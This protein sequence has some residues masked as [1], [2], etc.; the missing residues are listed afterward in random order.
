[1][2]SFPTQNQVLNAVHTTFTEFAHANCDTDQFYSYQ[3]PP[4]HFQRK[5][6]C[7]HTTTID[8][9][10]VSAVSRLQLS[11]C[12]PAL[13]LSA[14]GVKLTQVLHETSPYTKA[15]AVLPRNDTANR[16]ARGIRTVK[17]NEWKPPLYDHLR[18]CTMHNVYR[19]I[20][21]TACYRLLSD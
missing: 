21:R 5:E 14:P 4:V 12:R 15:A 20:Q 9:Y 16:I 11:A 13:H 10:L 17:S 3:Q 6:V 8:C 19:Y 1:M 2:N 7:L 18:W